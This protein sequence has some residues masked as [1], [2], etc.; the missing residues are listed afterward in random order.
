MI[1]KKL[2][3][4]VLLGSSILMA[5]QVCGIGNIGEAYKMNVVYAAENEPSQD[6]NYKQYKEKSIALVNDFFKKNIDKD[7][8]STVFNLRI[9]EK[10]EVNEGGKKLVEELEKEGKVKEGELKSKEITYDEVICYVSTHPVK[11]GGAPDYVVMFNGD[12]KEPI[13]IDQAITSAES[14]KMITDGSAKKVT[15]TTQE[16]E[17][18]KG[19]IEKYKLGGIITAECTNE[20]NVLMPMLDFKDKEN[21]NK[22][23]EILI[24]PATKELHSLNVYDSSVKT[25]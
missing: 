2:G 22:T 19:L 18:Y 1:L 7:A 4:V 11:E 8:E 12:T 20:R 16:K 23:V 17:R 13:Q 6:P 3:K 14:D 21:P 24:D 5:A 10:K 25:M 9:R 15:I